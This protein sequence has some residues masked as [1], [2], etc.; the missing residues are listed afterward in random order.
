MNVA[1]NME[2]IFVAVAVVLGLAS[3]TTTAAPVRAAMPAAQFVGTAA[4]AK[5]QV[6]SAPRL[7]VVRQAKS[8]G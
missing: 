7:A 2:T 3:Y 8:L 4:P 5:M 6:V 1:K